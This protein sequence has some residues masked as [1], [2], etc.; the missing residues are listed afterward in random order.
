M[1]EM[2]VASF[3]ADG[4]V[5]SEEEI[6]KRLTLGTKIREVTVSRTE[7]R[8]KAQYNPNQYF[9]SMKLDFS[10]LWEGFEE[11]LSTENADSKAAADISKMIRAH[12]HKTIM[13][14]EAYLSGVLLHFQMKDKVPMFPRQA[15]NPAIR[16]N[17]LR[18]AVE[19]EEV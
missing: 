9:V 19:A 17:T 7:T 8:Q 3:S 10:L 1:T 4:E 18:E 5:L 14:K 16:A 13:E 15:D 2:S 11:L 12:I 6:L